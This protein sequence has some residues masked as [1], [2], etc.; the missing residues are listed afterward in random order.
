M[1]EGSGL[2]TLCVNN[3][4]EALSKQNTASNSKWNDSHRACAL[5]ETRP[6]IS[7]GPILDGMN[8]IASDVSKR[9]E[10][11]RVPEDV[12]SRYGHPVIAQNKVAVEQKIDI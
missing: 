7:K 8:T 3:W 11:E 5:V 1:T 2:K 6:Q 10:Y 4:R 9:L 12:V